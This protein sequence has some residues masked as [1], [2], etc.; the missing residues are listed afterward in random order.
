MSYLN[1]AFK[2]LAALDE[3]AFDI[4]TEDGVE[5]LDDFID[6]DSFID[7]IEIIDPDAQDEDEI[8]D[9]YV[10]KVIL[11]CCVCHSKIYKDKE[12]VHIDE[13]VELANVDE[14]C[15]FCFT[16]GDGFK[17]VGEI[18][19]F[20]GEEHEEEIKDKEEIEVEEK[21]EES[22]KPAAL[23][24]EDAQK[25]VD[26]DMKR[27]H[28]ISDRTNRL[29][30][31]A[32]FQIIKDDHGDYE[33]AAGKYDESLSE[34][35]DDAIKE[36]F[37][38]DLRTALID[39]AERLGRSG[40]MDLKRYEAEF[41]DTIETLV[42]EKSWWEV[43]DCDIFNNL[44]N[45]HDIMGTI[46]CIIDS[47]NP[48]YKDL[49]ESIEFNESLSKKK[50]T[51][52]SAHDVFDDLFDKIRSD[53]EDY[54][55]MEES[56]KLT[57]SGIDPF[58]DEFFDSVDKDDFEV[59][60]QSAV[61]GAVSLLEGGIG[62]IED[63]VERSLKN[64]LE[65]PLNLVAAAKVFKILDGGLSEKDWDRVFDK[66]YNRL[67]DPVC[68][69]VEEGW[70]NDWDPWRDDEEIEESKKLTEEPVYD[71]APEFDYH[72]S[73]HG[74]ARVDAKDKK[75]QELYSYNTL[76]A[77]IVD[78]EPMVYNLQSA[79]TL[80]HVK[81]FLRQNG[82]KAETVKQIAKDYGRPWDWRNPYKYNGKYVKK[83]SESED[84]KEIVLDKRDKD[85]HSKYF[86]LR[87]KGYVRKWSGEGK[88]AMVPS[89]KPAKKR[90]EFFNEAIEELSVST[91]D[92][93]MT[94]RSEED[95][96]VTVTTEPKEVC[97]DK[98]DE[99][100]VPVDQETEDEISIDVDDFD[101]DSFDELGESYFK[102]V[103]DNVASFKTSSVSDKEGK[104]VV[105]GVIKFNSGK[106]KKTNFVF[107]ANK[108]KVRGKTVLLGENAQITPNKKA[109]TLKGAVKDNKFVCE[110]L[111]YKYN[112]KDVDGAFRRI[113]GTAKRGVSR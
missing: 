12:D 53:V 94:M 79:T 4:T 100:I 18:A 11:D 54:M 113:Y 41:Q 82:F 108:S 10:G 21:L 5:N 7:K 86:E 95:G 29:V 70:G 45:T 55:P 69:E 46:D 107:E 30:K 104:V 67:F 28:K 33:V 47:L 34:G 77:E 68:R 6:K 19:P 103:Y 1:E 50:L 43:T 90:P 60:Y 97:C 8:K 64:V 62:S 26:Y 48:E 71:L 9:S 102:N 101:E 112:T 24:I 110:S 109:F 99:V 37:E 36:S 65:E 93:K 91:D 3:D 51:E 61:R 42:P 87:D 84:E 83:V 44:F 74:K 57:E 35:T 15:P 80:R 63:A 92:S 88:I 23:S 27:Y 32:G 16:A 81:E 39:K 52:S 49:Q 106:S 73:F 72:K 78:G 38:T 66:V 40:T 22:D 96:K 111:N 98:D 25:W 31:K 75:N 76:V 2:R 59:A 58:S 89:D 20:G 17:V 85:F 56:K 105:E 14:E 13:E